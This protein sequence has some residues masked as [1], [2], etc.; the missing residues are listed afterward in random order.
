MNR[1]SEH[2]L[3][4]RCRAS[5]E[6]RETSRG[7]PDVLESAVSPARRPQEAAVLE[8]L[9]VGI[10]FAQ[11]CRIL[12]LN[13]ECEDV[14]GYTRQEL[15]GKSAARLFVSVR[16]YRRFARQARLAFEKG[17]ICRA[18]W[19]V[20]RK[21]GRLFWCRLEGR[22]LENQSPA[23]PD[24]SPP[25]QAVWVAEEITG[26][27]LAE[28][29][30]FRERERAQV[31]LHSIADAVITTDA[32]SRIDYL[33]PVAERLTG[34]SCREAQGL[35]LEQVFRVVHEYTGE[36]LCNP[37]QLC[38]QQNR[39]ISRADYAVLVNR[40]GGSVAVSD[41]TAPLCDRS[42]QLIGA[43]LVFRDVTEARKAARQLSYEA[44]HDALTG[45]YNRAAFIDSLQDALSRA[46]QGGNQ[47]VLCYLDLDRFKIVNDSCG[48]LAGDE[49]LRQVT[50]LLSRCLR[51]RDLLARLGGD[52][53]GLLLADCDV[54]DARRI[55]N[56]FCQAIADFRFAWD[57]KSF[58]I[59]VSIGL[60][61]VTAQ[62]QNIEAL[63]QA[64][65]QACF[66]A[67]HSGRG[68]VSVWQP[69]TL[70]TPAPP[71]PTIHWLEQFADAPDRRRLRVQIKRLLPLRSSAAA[72]VDY[73][74]LDSLLATPDGK[75]IDSVRMLDEAD[76]YDSLESLYCWLLQT[77]MQY[78]ARWRAAQPAPEKIKAFISLPRAA[79]VCPNFPGWVYK[80][81]QGCQLPASAVGFSCAE[82]HFIANFSKSSLCAMALKDLGCLFMVSEFGSGF[83]PFNYFRQISLDFLK[84]DA[85]LLKTFPHDPVEYTLLESIIRLSQ[86]MG[87]HTAAPPLSDP[88][89]RQRLRGLGLDFV[90]SGETVG[91][92]AAAPAVELVN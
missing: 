34:W 77:Q 18:E 76:R 10:A 37:G 19:L 48:H 60:V 27:R 79:L 49:L 24:Q 4:Q 16:E 83:S 73:C 64:A 13:R 31:T 59:G 92:A 63:L 39:V 52:E 43:V 58:S 29:A 69:P 71:A 25:A 78:Y 12:Y 62:S 23:A 89:A 81:L 17:G 70:A 90:V 28:E 84:I 68:Q 5:P 82:T 55:A 66:V 85:G 32:D 14:F 87:V 56:N 9:P 1:V 11:G 45:L 47:Y 8:Q 42:G 57:N 50:A 6:T 53:F 2:R 67:K 26:H 41:S 3:A 80:T 36:A 75:Q 15:A 65:D 74:Q 33:N 46:R 20:R 72:N 54:N 44:R 91:I 88:Q 61:G 30:L 7:E 86:A 22:L 38:I 21:D 40:Y 35:P 51:K